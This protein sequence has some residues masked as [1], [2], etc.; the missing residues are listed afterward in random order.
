MVRLIKYHALA[1][2]RY[3]Q[4]LKALA[5]DYLIRQAVEDV[6]P[7]TDFSAESLLNLL[8]VRG[9][10]GHA[11]VAPK[12]IARVESYKSVPAASSVA[13]SPEQLNL[14]GACGT[15]SVI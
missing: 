3:E 8:F 10:G 6:K 2:A 1:S 14:A 15:I 7:V 4:S 13:A 11:R 5:P 9:S 12:A